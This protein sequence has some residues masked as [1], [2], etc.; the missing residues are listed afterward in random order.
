MVSVLSLKPDFSAQNC[1]RISDLSGRNHTRH[2]IDVEDTIWVLNL[3]GFRKRKCQVTKA[4]SDPTEASAEYVEYHG[5]WAQA[6]G[7][8]AG[9]TSDGARD[10]P[11]SP[12]AFAF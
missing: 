4:L 6:C 8:G 9:A 2:L 3:Q 10:Q 1:L 5:G 12:R 7:C 11:L